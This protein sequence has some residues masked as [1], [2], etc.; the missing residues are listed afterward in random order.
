MSFHLSKKAHR[1]LIENNTIDALS[2][3]FQTDKFLVL[4]AEINTE[5]LPNSRTKRFIKFQYDGCVFHFELRELVT[6]KDYLVNFSYNRKVVLVAKM[7]LRRIP[8]K[9]IPITLFTV[10]EG[11][12]SLAKFGDWINQISQISRIESEAYEIESIEKKRETLETKN[13]QDFDFGVYDD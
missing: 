13:N 7:R 2:H 5:N 10:H 8:S 1:I 4:D 12:I 6:K 3:I 11:D 9:T